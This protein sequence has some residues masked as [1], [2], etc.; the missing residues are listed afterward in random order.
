MIGI[1]NYKAGNSHSVMNACKKIGVG[2]KYVARPEDFDGVTA[3]ILPGVGSAKA[4][5]GSLREL[6]VLPRLEELVLK[7]KIPFLGIC[8]GLQILF[9]HSEEDDVDCLGWIG[10]TVV[11]FDNRR[12]RVPQIGWNR[13]TWKKSD[14]VLAGLGESEF[15]YFVNSYYAK[16]A[17]EADILAAADYDGEFCA[18]I[19][20][21]N[22]YASQ[23]H[24]EKSGMVGLTFLKNFCEGGAASCS[25]ID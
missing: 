22:I 24:I 19:R 17:D 14:P 10:G 25:R 18:M 5:L 1:I 13:L 21:G 23:C 12:V 6:G 15:F 4:T 20:H 3:V 7:E 9:E 16:P 11:E 2:C 8:V